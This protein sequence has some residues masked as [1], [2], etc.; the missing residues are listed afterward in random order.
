MPG[1]GPCAPGQRCVRSASA[2]RA[3]ARTLAEAPGEGE[4]GVRLTAAVAAGAA[5]STVAAADQAA[6]EAAVVTVVAVL[7][8]VVL[9]AA[10]VAVVLAVLRDVHPVEVGRLPALQR[11]VHHVAPD[12]AG[13]LATEDLAV[14]LAA[15][16]DVDHLALVGRVA[17]PDRAGHVRGVAHEPGRVAEVGRTGLARAG[18]AAAQ[19]GL[20][21]R[22]V[23]DDAEQQRVDGV[24]RLLRHRARAGRLR[25]RQ[26]LVLLTDPLAD[27]LDGDRGA[28]HAPRGEGGVAVRHGQRGH[29]LGAEGDRRGL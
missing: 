5:V 13:H 3:L 14:P 17:D 4:R 26:R 16:G 20:R 1:P 10:T 15:D 7:A 21:A 25:H 8:V 23:L 18:T 28:V 19:S 22:A 12:R 29:L 9:V 2:S 27:R 24:G 6:A 11:A